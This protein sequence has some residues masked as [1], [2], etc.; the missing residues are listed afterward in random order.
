MDQ[1]ASP[2]AAGWQ[3]ELDELVAC[4]RIALQHAGARAIVGKRIDLC[5]GAESFP[6]F[7]SIAGDATDDETGNVADILPADS[8]FGR[9]TIDGWP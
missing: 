3:A 5:P 6:E 4:K 8:V 2:P 7:G 1:I 9:G